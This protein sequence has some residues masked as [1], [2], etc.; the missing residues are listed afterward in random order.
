MKKRMKGYFQALPGK[1]LAYL[2]RLGKDLK[3]Y[4]HHTMA[5]PLFTKV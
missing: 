3:D 2:N 5:T 4:A 1:N